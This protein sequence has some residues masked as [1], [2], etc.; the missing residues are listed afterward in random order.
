MCAQCLNALWNICTFCC[1]VQFEPLNNTVWIPIASYVTRLLT[2]PS[3]S[4]FFRTRR[5]GMGCF[6]ADV[7]MLFM[8]GTPLRTS[9]LWTHVI[10]HIL[11][12][13]YRLS[14]VT[15]GT[16]MLFHAVEAKLP[17]S[18]NLGRAI[19]QAVSRWLPTAAVRRSKPDLVMWDLWWDKVALGQVFSEFFGFPCNRRSLYQLLHNH[20]HV[21]SGECTIGQ[22]VAAVLGLTGT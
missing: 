4:I 18:R 1:G 2:D 14:T 8:L 3:S 21:S 6:E 5:E 15:Q 10:L 11:Y 16:S 19:A 7:G 17:L 9:S 20:P 12:T 13:L 22:C